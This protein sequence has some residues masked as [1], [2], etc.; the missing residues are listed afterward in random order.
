MVT[1]GIIMLLSACGAAYFYVQKV[2]SPDSLE[3][4]NSAAA[5]KAAQLRATKNENLSL[6][7]IRTGG[8]LSL[9]NVG[10]M[11]ESFDAQVIGRHLY[12]S[13]RSSWY[14]IEGDKG[15]GKVFLSL[16]TDRT[17]TLSQPKLGELGVNEE[18]F[19]S[20]PAKK[21]CYQGVN[22]VFEESG[23]ASYCENGDELAPEHFK[24]WE[25][26]NEDGSAF[27]TVTQWEDGSLEAS[28]SVP[29][30]E[31]QISILTNS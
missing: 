14:E 15:N 18:G 22:F 16:D 2:K 26:E 4:L 5:S 9:S 6:E 28:Y 17:V 25:Y 31:N 27:L 7:N 1:L 21:L 12:K 29:F 19:S 20:S 24:Y 11:M 3:A 30:Q 13:G 8:M 23:S 10:P